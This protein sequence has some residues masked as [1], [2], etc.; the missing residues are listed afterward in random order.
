[1][2]I[3]VGAHRAKLCRGDWRPA[4]LYKGGQYIAGA[5]DSA[6]VTLP[7][8]IEDTYN[9]HVM[10]TALG[11][12]RQ[13]STPTPDTP[14]PIAA[15]GGTVTADG[16]N[17]L[18][19]GILYTNK[20]GNLIHKA[21]YL[22]SGETLVSSLVTSDGSTDGFVYGYSYNIRLYHSDQTYTSLQPNVA[23]V[24][25]KDAERIY[26]NFSNTQFDIYGGTAEWFKV[27][28]QRGSAVY[29]YQP[30]RPPTQITL[31]TLRAIPDGSGGWVARDSMTPVPYMPGW[32]EVTRN[33][34]VLVLDANSLIKEYVNGL[35]YDS[36][37]NKAVAP[38]LCTHHTHI[39][40]QDKGSDK[41][42]GVINQAVHIFSNKTADE[43]KIWLNEQYV[44]GTPV[45]VWY[46]LATPTT[47]RVYLG[48]LK[49]YPQYTYISA[50]GDYPP[51]M[52][53]TAKLNREE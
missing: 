37:K 27:Q 8:A 6:P 53:A 7:G 47:E 43:Y 31:P 35:Y 24:L 3:Y 9:D 23:T 13:D 19:A 50:D 46:Q 38:C 34:G 36:L 29:P 44:A 40:Y 39:N 32:Y 45:T 33:I 11:K 41:F 10:L 14:V 20:S 26:I 1:M 22:K 18:N 51:D 48:E 12:G 21:M 2:S 49:S 16:L 15:S 30:Y 4:T 5:V 52:T 17:L 42:S 28:I 25:P